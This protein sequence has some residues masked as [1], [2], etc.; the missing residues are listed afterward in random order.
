MTERYDRFTRNDVGLG[1]QEVVLK[2]FNSRWKR[3]FS[4]EAYHV[5]DE[6]R[7]ESLRL[8]HIGSTSVPGLEAKP[9]IDMLGSVASLTELDSRRHL[10]ER[11]GYEYKGENGIK[12]RRYCVLQNPEKTTAYVH[13]HIFERGD[14]EI[15][16]HLNFRDH[17]RRSESDRGDYQKLKKHL[18]EE[19]KVPREHYS[20]AKNDIVTRIQ[21]R[22]NTRSHNNRVVAILGTAAGS[23][24]TA[25][26]VREA[27]QQ[28]TLEI[29]DLSSATVNPFSHADRHDDDFLKI[30]G[31]ALEADLIVLAT[32]VYWYAMAGVMKDFMDRLA[33]LLSGEA[34]QLG[35][36]LYGKKVELVAT[37]YDPKLPLGFEVP[38]AATAIYFGMDYLGARYKSA[39]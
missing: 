33:D 39:R 20:C 28:S 10:L 14:A 30:V 35:E 32:P 37:G 4:Q 3:V 21:H 13:L 27:Y 31:R 36:S 8:Y 9:V 7:D 38:F 12:G 23:S 6:V 22:A 26:F 5:F 17:L 16:K 15:H 1:Q 19:V 11:L 18:V 24:G 25:E 2:P 34:K 29:V